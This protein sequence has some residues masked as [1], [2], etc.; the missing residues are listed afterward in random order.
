[1]FASAK[2]QPTVP[3]TLILDRSDPYDIA[4]TIGNCVSEDSGNWF[5]PIAP[6]ARQRC[7]WRSRLIWQRSRFEC[8]QRRLWHWQDDLQH[9]FA[10][11]P[12]ISHPRQP[13]ANFVV[14][15]ETALDRAHRRAGPIRRCGFRQL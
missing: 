13:T 9:R 2:P 4:T 6:W 8:R 5:A 12:R 14:R 3:G 7:D 10:I 15:E 11:N 1:L